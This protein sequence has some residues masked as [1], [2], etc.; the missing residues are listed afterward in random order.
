VKQYAQTIFID[1]AA[2]SPLPNG[3]VFT[4]DVTQ[5]QHYETQVSS[6]LDIIGGSL[7]GQVVMREVRGGG[8]GKNLR[9]VPMPG[10]DAR[11]VP[12]NPGAATPFNQPLRFPGDLPATPQVE[13]AGQ[14]RTGADGRP[15]LGSGEGAN[16]TIQYHPLTWLEDTLRTGRVGNLLPDDVLLHE[17]VHALRMMHG[18]VQTLDMGNTDHTAKYGNTEEFYA[19]LIANIY[20]SERNAKEGRGQALRGNV[21]PVSQFQAL[22]GPEAQSKIFYERYKPSIKKLCNEMMGLCHGGGFKG[23]KDVPSPFNPIRDCEEEGEALRQK[24]YGGMGL[25]DFP[26]P[27]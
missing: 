26:G 13:K 11:A 16:V 12:S 3:Q 19:V 6:I 27:R 18:M 25:P 2:P 1:G 14:V 5:A 23:L 8:L 20:I 7:S 24:Y 9:I 17:L 22:T 15:I 21:G 10:K 4:P